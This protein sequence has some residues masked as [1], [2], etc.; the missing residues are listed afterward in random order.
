MPTTST[1]RNTKSANGVPIAVHR[2]NMAFQGNQAGDVDVLHWSDGPLR[3]WTKVATNTG[4]T[5]AQ[6]VAWAKTLI[7]EV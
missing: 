3:G 4:M 7:V 1:Y 5:I 2:H 6:A